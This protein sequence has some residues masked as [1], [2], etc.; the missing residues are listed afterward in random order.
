MKGETYQLK[1]RAWNVNGPGEFSEIGY[2]TAAEA[3]SRPGTPVYI[4]SDFD[5][6]SLSF[7]PSLDDGGS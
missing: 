5:Q 2:I 6:I 4:S 1:Y 3:P 7:S